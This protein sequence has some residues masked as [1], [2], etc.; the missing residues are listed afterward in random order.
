MPVEETEEP[1]R[2]VPGSGPRG[3]R[4]FDSVTRGAHQT[5]GRLRSHPV[6]GPAYRI[7]VGIVGALVVLLGLVL[8]PFP[9]P[10]WLIVII[11]L[12][13]LASE[14][15]WAQRLLDF[16]KAKVHDW[17]TWMAARSW[18]VRLGV[19]LATAV[20]VGAIL[21]TT[22]YLIGLPGW[23]P[24]WLVPPLPGIEQYSSW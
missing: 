20:F 1:R 14:F 22:A 17:T 9:G 5:R 24:G 16:V 12:L 10:G 19:G 8:V 2:H 4:R 13:I 7:T 15:A 23:I 18:P 21:Y 3:P 11:G 6:A